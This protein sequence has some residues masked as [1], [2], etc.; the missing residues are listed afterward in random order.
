MTALGIGSGV[1]V[2]SLGQPGTSEIGNKFIAEKMVSQNL[3]DNVT[4]LQGELITISSQV[5]DMINNCDNALTE[6]QKQVETFKKDGKSKDWFNP[7][8][9]FKIHDKKLYLSKINPNFIS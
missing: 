2:G 6:V 9:K 5:R 7:D 1:Q 8:A 3:M 4:D